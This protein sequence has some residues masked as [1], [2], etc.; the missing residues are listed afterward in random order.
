MRRWRPF[1]F[2]TEAFETRQLPGVTVIP[3]DT[4]LIGSSTGS[5][6]DDADDETRAHC[7]VWCPG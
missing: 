2:F 5:D 1:S 7:F 6:A 4:C 3:C